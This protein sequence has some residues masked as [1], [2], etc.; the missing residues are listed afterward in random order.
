M[1][2]LAI[3]PSPCREA[4]LAVPP[5][6]CRESHQTLTL[7]VEPAALAHFLLV[8]A[9]HQCNP[10]SPAEFQLPVT[11]PDIN[12]RLE[13]LCLS[14]TEHALGGECILLAWHGTPGRTTGQVGT[15]WG[16]QG[17][18]GERPWGAVGPLSS[19]TIH[20][21]RRH[22]QR[23]PAPC[24]CSSSG[25]DSGPRRAR[26]SSFP[27]GPTPPGHTGVPAPWLSQPN[28]GTGGVR[29]TRRGF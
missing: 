19:H 25:G 9:R 3:P 15:G 14:M 27:R 8:R 22:M 20:S 1:A 12:N 17:T 2:I 4:A 18:G 24:S 7:K 11:E 10:S 16:W 28:A 23:A 26:C 5:S 6:P 13:S 29:N 21:T